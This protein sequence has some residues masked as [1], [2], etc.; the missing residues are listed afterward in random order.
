VGDDADGGAGVDL[1]VRRIPVRP[2]DDHLVGVREAGR[3]GEHGAGVAYSDPV[4]EEVPGPA[5]GS[6]AVDGA[7]DE[8]AG[9][10]AW[11]WT[12]TES[13][14]EQVSASP[15]PSIRPVRPARGSARVCAVTARSSRSTPRVS[16][17]VLLS[18]RRER[19]RLTARH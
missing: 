14:S 9:R 16:S 8:H 11:V 3:G 10:V 13:R 4:A 1:G 17:Y 18:P 6:G 7:E 19:A 12:R 15:P 2:L 5:E